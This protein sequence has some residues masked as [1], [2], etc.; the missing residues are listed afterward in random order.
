M[1]W[2]NYGTTTRPIATGARGMVTSAHPLASLAGVRTLLAG[3]NAIDAAV[4]VAA[5]LNVVEPYMSGLGGDGYM[6]VHICL[7]Y[8]SPSPRDS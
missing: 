4:A 8:T 7:L 5:A 3:G 6:L 1:P 2:Y